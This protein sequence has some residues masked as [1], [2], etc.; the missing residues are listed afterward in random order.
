MLS[1]SS[2]DCN[3][4][5]RACACIAA[6]TLRC[7][8]GS[9]FILCHVVGVAPCYYLSIVCQSTCS[10]IPC[11]NFVIDLLYNSVK[12]FGVTLVAADTCV[13]PLCV[14]I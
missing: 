2:R 11:P 8:A 10:V 12:G 4:V 14:I 5:V 3:L 7:N 1:V 13:V 6:R 9:D